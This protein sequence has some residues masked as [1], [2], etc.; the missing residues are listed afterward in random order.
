MRVDMPMPAKADR[1]DSMMTLKTSD[2][3]AKMPAAVAFVMYLIYLPFALLASRPMAS[4]A[5]A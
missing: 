2:K 3:I 5:I 1:T 4:S